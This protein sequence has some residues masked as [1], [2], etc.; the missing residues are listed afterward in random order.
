MTRSD[1][2]ALVYECAAAMSP[3]AIERILSEPLAQDAA[4]FE[5]YLGQ[6]VRGEIDP[7]ERTLA[8]KKLPRQTTLDKIWQTWEKLRHSQRDNV[9]DLLATQL[10]RAPLG[11]ELAKLVAAL[12]PLEKVYTNF[13]FSKPQRVVEF[14]QFLRERNIDTEPAKFQRL[15]SLI[16]GCRLGVQG[17]AEVNQAILDWAYEP[18]QPRISFGQSEGPWLAW[19]RKLSHPPLKAFLGAVGQGSLREFLGAN[20]KLLDEPLWLEFALVL[21]YAE[22]TLLD[23]FEQRIMSGREG[24]RLANATYMTFLGVWA[25]L[26]FE[27]ANL[28]S[29]LM[30]VSYQVGLQVLKEFAQRPYFPLYGPLLVSLSGA[31]LGEA[32]VH[33]REPLHEVEDIPEMAKIY[34]LLGCALRYQGRPQEAAQFF[35]IATALAQRH[36][37]TQT[38][39]AC[40]VNSGWALVERG[41]PREAL[42]LQEKAL[43]LTRTVGHRVGESHTLVALG[44]TLAA[45]YRHP[46][47]IDYLN[48]GLGLA[49]DLGETP[50]ESL[51]LLGLGLVYEATERHSEAVTM[52]M[53]A[54]D[55]CVRT[56][57]LAVLGQVFLALAEAQKSLQKTKLA[58][59]E[60]VQALLLL[61]RLQSPRW[62]QAGGL[63]V[64]LR[65]QLGEEAFAETLKSVTDGMSQGGFQRLYEH[66][67]GLLTEFNR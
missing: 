21:R 59:Q 66:V 56:Q 57:D 53:E 55:L 50:A 10:V 34:N 6:F 52:L 11:T 48:R 8:K 30:E 39:A 60:G 62:R 2:K 25:E 44:H 31:A 33:L 29:P 46:E 1:Y 65:G 5:D 18:Q 3:E 15:D 12:D 17:C 28:E 35:E 63:L 32:V 36:A 4:G 51:G 37:Q 20:L 13:D 26:G 42:V 61:H 23:L 24:D 54:R 47:A 40:Y 43:V 67:L 64:V 9:L 41:S 19:G 38:E 16:N 22:F 58:V 49:R 45:L 27:L 14:L 7:T